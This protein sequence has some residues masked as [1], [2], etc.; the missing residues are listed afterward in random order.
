MKNGRSRPEAIV[1][2]WD[3]TLVDTWPVI[4]DA[5]T[6]T[7]RAMG[8]S[9]WTFEE[10]RTRVRRS[11]RDA[12]PRLFGERW[13]EARGIFYDAFERV[14]IDRL[15]PLDDADELLGALSDADVHLAVLS[16]K[17][18]RYL[19]AEAAHL[20]WTGYFDCLVGAGDAPRDKPAPVALQLALARAPVGPG[21]RV[22]IV[23]DA[24]IDM[25]VAHK[26]GC[27]PVLL[28][29][30]PGDSEFAAWPPGHCFASCRTLLE[31]IEGW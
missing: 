17:T 3:N 31:Y 6:V 20:G 25:E 13:K 16:N 9:S 8:Q 29:W 28:H 1:F 15:R 7:F 26:T 5:L 18:G 27:R 30:D 23:G 10:T 2:D 4:H 11:L 12:F 21:P 19:R 14:H 22:W 24:G